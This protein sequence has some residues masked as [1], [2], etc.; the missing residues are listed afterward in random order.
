MFILVI[1]VVIIVCS[2]ISS[3]ENKTKTDIDKIKRNNKHS[4]NN[5][6]EIKKGKIG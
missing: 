1:I 3:N 5:D 4:T 2:V 6:I